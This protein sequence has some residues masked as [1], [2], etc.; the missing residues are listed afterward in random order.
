LLEVGSA[1]T[2]ITAD[3]TL[4]PPDLRQELKD[5]IRQ[6]DTLAGRALAGV[7][8]HDLD[9]V[10]LTGLPRI[11]P[12]LRTNRGGHD[13]P[14][15]LLVPQQSAHLTRRAP[16][17]FVDGVGVALGGRHLGPAHDR[18]DGADVDVLQ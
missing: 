4:W 16:A 15:E 14:P 10:P 18:H 1:A 5:V 2:R 13:S 12:P 3:V 17:Q 8:P 9:D 7:D 11:L 6:L